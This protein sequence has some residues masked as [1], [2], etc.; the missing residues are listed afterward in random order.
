MIWR[1]LKKVTK[2]QEEQFRE[3][4]TKSDL[5]F[6]DK[7]SMVLSAYLVLLLPVFL[8]L[9]VLSLLICWIFGIF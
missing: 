1:R 8:I 2:E 9:V 4:M 3:D 5:S 7:M 6:K